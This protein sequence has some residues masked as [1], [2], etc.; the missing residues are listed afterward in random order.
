MALSADSDRLDQFKKGNAAGGHASGVETIPYP[1]A[2]PSMTSRRFPAPWHA[3]KM[4]GGY[5]V[6]DVNGQALAYLYSRENTTEA[7]QAKRRGGSPST[8]R[9]C[10]SCS[11]GQAD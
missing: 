7:L 5:V 2:S 11:K 1:A 3:D 9:G 6:R 10:R 8:S 4:P